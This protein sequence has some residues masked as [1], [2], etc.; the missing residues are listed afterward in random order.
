MK[1]SERILTGNPEL[2]A[3]QYLPRFH[4]VKVNLESVLAYL[5][6][7]HERT[8]KLEEAVRKLERLANPMRYVIAPAHQSEAER[9]KLIET[10][11]ATGATLLL[12]RY[13]LG[14]FDADGNQLS[15]RDGRYRLVS[16]EAMRRRNEKTLDRYVGLEGLH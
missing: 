4:G 10:L 16:A 7:E 15:P 1:P 5:D 11:K 2:D 9:A 3:A 13:G 14:W 6:E 12:L 8:T